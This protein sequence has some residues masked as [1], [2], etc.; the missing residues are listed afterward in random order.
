MVV[1]VVGGSVVGVKI[2][3]EVQRSGRGECV[4]DKL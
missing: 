1:V 2:L 4:G 3:K